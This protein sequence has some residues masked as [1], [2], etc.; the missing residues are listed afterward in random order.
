MEQAPN[1]TLT[2]ADRAELHL[3]YTVS[4]S[5]IGGFKQQQWSVTSHAL[6][7]AP[8]SPDTPVSY[9]AAILSSNCTG[10]T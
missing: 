7:D 3:L 5:D 4:V 10:L 1:N 6:W 2:E 8:I 9:T